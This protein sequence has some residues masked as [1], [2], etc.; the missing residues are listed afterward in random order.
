M[1]AIR[2]HLGNI[3][4]KKLNDEIDLS[5]TLNCDRTVNLSILVSDSRLGKRSVFEFDVQL[6]VQRLD[7]RQTI[8]IGNEFR[9]ARISEWPD[10]RR[11][12]DC[13]MSAEQSAGAKKRQK[14]ET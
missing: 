14:S 11:D 5:R 3:N 10:Y 9:G 1:F 4:G 8:D 13:L 12:T 6:A 7:G 2:S